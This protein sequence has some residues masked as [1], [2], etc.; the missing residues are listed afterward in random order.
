MVGKCVDYVLGLARECV[1]VDGASSLLKFGRSALFR[2][3][4]HLGLLLF[5]CYC[6]G[7]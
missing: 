6:G 2:T 7:K 5:D 4:M 3:G 1:T